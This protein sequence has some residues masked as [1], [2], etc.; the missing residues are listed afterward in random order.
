MPSRS[1]SS[2]HRARVSAA[3]R[4]RRRSSLL[5][6]RT[7]LCCLVGWCCGG[8]PGLLKVAGSGNMLLILIPRRET[9]HTNGVRAAE[10]RGAGLGPDSRTV[11]H[12]QQPYDRRDQM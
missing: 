9:P 12:Q 11:S 5:C 7:F 8:G 6:G 10:N 2:S 3:C 4:R 1:W